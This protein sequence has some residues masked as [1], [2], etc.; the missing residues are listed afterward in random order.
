MIQL[1]V[2]ASARAWLAEKAWPL[3]LEHGVDWRAGAYHEWLQPDLGCTASYRRLR[4]VA[5]QTYVF[6]QAA[7]AG[8]P[9]AREAVRL[10]VNFLRN[11]AKQDDGG[12]AWRFALDNAPTD[13]TRDLYDHAFVL[14][15]LAH[16]AAAL[17]KDRALPAE[18]AALLSYLDLRFSHPSGG[19]RE[20]IPD[21]LPR[22][23]NPHMH[24]L[25]ALLAAHAAFDD[26]VYLARATEVVTLFLDRLLQPA[27]SV[28]PEF[29][30]AELRP[31]RDARGCF[32]IEPGHHYEWVWLLDEYLRATASSPH[33]V[34]IER[35]I[36]M[37]ME[38]A[39]RW[40]IDARTGLATDVIHS[41]GSVQSCSFRLWPQTERLKAVLR[42]PALS[43][44]SPATC[45]ALLGS[46]LVGV[47][48]GLWWERLSANGPVRGEASP[49]SSLYHLTCAML[50]AQR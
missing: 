31:A 44:A 15:S 34:E 50:E 41:D 38:H 4:V 47:P 43:Q 13:Q 6:A 19:Y 22:R 48:A 10:G 46:Y 33:S 9:R 21:K 35:A 14:L 28:L 26:M 32:V 49:A 36:T 27:E 11:H 37:L 18:A 17:P 42:R 20:A 5:R 3:W 2:P 12:Y 8:V 45:I 39:E 40:G 7:Q 1:S 29:F 16:A 30:D 24:L 25:E 23:Q